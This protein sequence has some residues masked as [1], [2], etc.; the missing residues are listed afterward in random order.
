MP[1]EVQS[2]ER[3]RWKEL[4]EEGPSVFTD[5]HPSL[6]LL[7]K[8]CSLC[9][10]YAQMWKNTNHLL[11]YFKERWLKFCKGQFQNPGERKT[12]MKKMHQHNGTLVLVLATP[13]SD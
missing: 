7:V 8:E 5:F 11:D 4:S 2:Q 6:S 13:S 10:L 12:E 9:L 1:L 3:V